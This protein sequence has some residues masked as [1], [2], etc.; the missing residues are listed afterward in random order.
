MDGTCS[1]LDAHTVGL[2]FVATLCQ[3]AIFVGDPN[4]N[5]RAPRRR[6]DADAY[7]CTVCAG[8]QTACSCIC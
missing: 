7:T 2:V 5:A 1:S 8:D 3:Y 6:I 4:G